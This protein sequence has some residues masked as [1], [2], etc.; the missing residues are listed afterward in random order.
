MHSPES[1]SSPSCTARLQ[2]SVATSTTCAFAALPCLALGFTGPAFAF[3]AAAGGAAIWGW[4]GLGRIAEKEQ[5]IGRLITERD[6]FF[7]VERAQALR[8]EAAELRLRRMGERV[9][10]LY[11]EYDAEARSFVYLSPVF[12]KLFGVKSGSAYADAERIFE[13]FDEARRQT[14]Q[15]A[16]A[17]GTGTERV[18]LEFKT[19]EGLLRRVSL[20]AEV[21][22]GDARLVRGI[23]T[24][25][26]VGTGLALPEG[27]HADEL[28][29]AA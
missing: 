19:P 7:S 18:R 20:T 15:A 27:P 11:F 16:L 9:R 2:R 22:A 26:R 14:L 21:D 3:A 17:E 6:R 23:L 10:E 5:A 1:H 4:A 13:R 25:L 29:R 12:E 8:A 28:S 24:L